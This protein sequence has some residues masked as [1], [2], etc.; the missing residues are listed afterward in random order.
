MILSFFKEL[1]STLRLMLLMTLT[2]GYERNDTAEHLDSS[3]WRHLPNAEHIDR[4]IASV[5]SHPEA[6]WGTTHG[7]DFVAIIAAKDAAWD[8]ARDANWDA[9]RRAAFYQVWHA[10]W[11]ATWRYALDSILALIAYD[12]AAKYLK[13]SSSE[14]WTSLDKD[15]HAARLMLPAV[16]AFER[17]KKE[18]L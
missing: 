4:I 3:A 13:M 2:R 6:W 14:L 9:A 16:I 10:P 1:Y 8:L 5:K 18:Q 17:I 11:D 15:D 7:D 12:D